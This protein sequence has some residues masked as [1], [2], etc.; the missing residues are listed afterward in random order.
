MGACLTTSHKI[1][2][3]SAVTYYPEQKDPDFRVQV[4][5]GG[6][7]SSSLYMSVDYA[8]EFAQQILAALPADDREVVEA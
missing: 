6:S 3:R 8:R 7:A 4:F 1:E 5:L 2:R